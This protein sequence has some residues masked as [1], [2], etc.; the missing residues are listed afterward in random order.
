MEKQF[1]PSNP[2]GVRLGVIDNVMVRIRNG[3]SKLKDLLRSLTSRD[4]LLR[5]ESRLYLAYV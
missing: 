1:Y 2:I 4:W 3:C 5:I